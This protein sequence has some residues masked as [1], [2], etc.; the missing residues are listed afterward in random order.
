VDQEFEA[1]QI[2]RRSMIKRIGAGAAIAWAAPAITSIG[3]R[4]AAQ[5][6]P[7]PGCVPGLCRDW[8]C[9]DEIT[10]CGAPADLGPCVCD[11]DTEG[12]CFCWNNEFCDVVADCASSA[13]CPAGQRCATSCCGQTCLPEC[14]SDAG[15]AGSA[16]TG[17][18]SAIGVI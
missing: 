1:S 2:S 12:R 16:R 15:G 18:R 4:A 8:N 10:E 5:E 11:V 17:G 13:D 9:G 3:S 6:S 14:G 7:A